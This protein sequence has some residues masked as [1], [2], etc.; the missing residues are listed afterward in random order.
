MQGYVFIFAILLGSEYLVEQTNLNIP[1]SIIGLLVLF[2]YFSIKG[3]ISDE[4]GES[5][6]TLLKYLPL[7]LVPIG[8]G[9]KELFVTFDSQLIA[10]L[11]ASFIALL[12]AVFI[13][14][15]TIWIIKY[16][17]DKFSK[18]KLVSNEN[19]IEEES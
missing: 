18:K 5:A 13:T 14:V 15:A 10:M 3:K 17:L 2:V 16:L 11:G 4:I 8:V 12:L 7:M 9:I 6:G 1:G 19:S